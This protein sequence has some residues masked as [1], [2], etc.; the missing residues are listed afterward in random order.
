MV[1]NK[2]IKEM[3]DGLKKMSKEF[4]SGEYKNTILRDEHIAK[5]DFAVAVLEKLVESPTDEYSKKTYAIT[6]ESEYNKEERI[7]LAIVKSLGLADVVLDRFEQIYEKG[8]ILTMEEV[9]YMF[10]GKLGIDKPEDSF[11]FADITVNGVEFRIYIEWFYNDDIVDLS[12]FAKENR[13]RRYSNG[14]YG[15]IDLW[16]T[17][18]RE[19]NVSEIDVLDK[20]NYILQTNFTAL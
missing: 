17:V 20:I 9:W 8:Y 4:E 14:V 6:L 5:V 12:I 10:D 13:V 2:D 7:T 19:E 1:T 11:Y 15:M 3:I 18:H 16:V